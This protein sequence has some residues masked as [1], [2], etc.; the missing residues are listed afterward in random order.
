[1]QLI[2]RMT[3]VDRELSLEAV[4]EL[5]GWSPYHLHRGFRA[6]VGETPKGYQ[7]RLRLETALLPLATT[8]DPIH[9]IAT[10]VG[11]QSHEGFVRAFRTVFGITPSAFRRRTRGRWTRDQTERMRSAG[12]CIGLHGPTR[13]LQRRIPMSLDVQV[14]EHNAV[15]VLFIRRRVAP[16][17]LS[18]TFAEC[19]PRVFMHCQRNGLALAGPPFVRYVQVGRGLMT[20]ECGMQ[21]ADPAPPEDNIEAGT[22]GG[23]PIAVATHMGPYETLD[24]THAAIE[25]WCEANDRTP[26]GPPW[27]E[28]LTDPADHPDPADW[29]TK[30]AWPLKP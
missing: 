1:M 11:F 23:G 3:R 29:Q 2:H 13:P 10:R 26:A 27:E 24:A 17:D 21:L 9:D 19:L 7:R 22:L 30:V 20:V 6:M 18:T 4:A 12:R 16:A 25:R 5:G 8:D 28:Y 15:P 14:H